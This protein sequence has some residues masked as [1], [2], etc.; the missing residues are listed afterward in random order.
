MHCG[1]VAQLGIRLADKSIPSHTAI[2]HEED[3]VIEAEDIDGH[4]RPCGQPLDDLDDAQLP[5][6]SPELV[7]AGDS[8]EVV[9]GT[10][11]DHP[12]RRTGAGFEKPLG[13]SADGAIAANR[14]HALPL[15]SGPA[16]LLDSVPR[17]RPFKAIIFV[18]DV[19]QICASLLKPVPETLATLCPGN[20]VDQKLYAHRRF[21]PL[22]DHDGDASSDLPVYHITVGQAV[23]RQ[24]PQMMAH[25]KFFGEGLVARYSPLTH[26]P[27]SARGEA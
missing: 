12:Q 21:R 16:C 20:R 3:L 2:A 10:L 26:P 14:D 9:A 5:T 24:R 17:V 13:H 8:G 18:L 25:T 6:S 23:I 15:G 7:D 22:V 27:S 1:V 4:G 19:S 11:G